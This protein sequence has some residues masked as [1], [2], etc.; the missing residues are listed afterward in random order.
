[1]EMM[2]DYVLHANKG[3]EHL[4]PK[5]GLSADMKYFDLDSLMRMYGESEVRKF[6][7]SHGV[8]L[9]IRV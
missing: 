2:S 1:M 4:V 3:E 9:K 6:L 7:A 8:T 5:Y